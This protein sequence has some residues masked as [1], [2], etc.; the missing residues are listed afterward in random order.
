MLLCA[1]Q[2]CHGILDISLASVERLHRHNIYPIVLLL[3]FRHHKQI[4]EVC[5][6]HHPPAERISQKEAKEMFELAAKMEQE[7][8]HVISGECR[9]A[10]ASPHSLTLT[11]LC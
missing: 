6:S 5:E 4:R 10:A 9:A 2:S 7:Y 11:R 1:L 8:K 3:K